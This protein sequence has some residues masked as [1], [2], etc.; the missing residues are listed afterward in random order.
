M[1]GYLSAKFFASDDAILGAIVTSHKHRNVMSRSKYGQ[2]INCGLTILIVFLFSL[3]HLR[4]A[5]QL[6]S[7]TA[8]KSKL[9]VFLQNAS[10]NP[11][12][13]TLRKMV[14]RLNSIRVTFFQNDSIWLASQS[15]T[16]IRVIFQCPWI[17]D[18]QIQFACRETYEHL[19]GQWWSRF[20]QFSLLPG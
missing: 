3:C 15:M 1:S 7:G 9:P 14:T 18:G 16:R 17:P 10:G 12:R 6:R 4:N 13:V 19:I 8:D 5:T 11:T 2:I 20:A